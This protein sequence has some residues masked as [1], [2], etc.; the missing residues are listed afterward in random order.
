MAFGDDSPWQATTEPCL[1]IAQNDVHYWTLDTGP[2]D[3]QAPPAS[4]MQG[5]LRGRATTCVR[6]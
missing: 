4:G 1:Y 5:R 6:R 2:G 3:A